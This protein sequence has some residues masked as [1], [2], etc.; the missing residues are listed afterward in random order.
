MLSIACLFVITACGVDREDPASS[1]AEQDSAFTEDGDGL[2]G[3]SIEGLSNV[4]TGKENTP[5]RAI[6]VLSTFDAPVRHSAGT[7]LR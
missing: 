3:S 1:R 5:V 6:C 4:I 7:G 2:T